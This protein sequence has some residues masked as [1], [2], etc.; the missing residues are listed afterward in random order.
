MRVVVERR[1]RCGRMSWAAPIVR[2]ADGLGLAA[3]DL[4]LAAGRLGAT[5][6]QEVRPLVQKQN[7]VRLRGYD[8]SDRTVPVLAISE[9]RPW[10][11]AHR[12]HRLSS[13]GLSPR[14]RR[15][16][17]SSP[18]ASSWRRP[19]EGSAGPAV[20]RS[21]PSSS[22]RSSP[23]TSSRPRGHSTSAT[24]SRRWRRGTVSARSGPAT[25][26]TTFCSPISGEVS[27]AA[28]MRPLRRPQL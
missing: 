4:G 17:R 2:R 9:D 27:P 26:G 16:P 24:V 11:R 15:L 5:A 19:A 6:D 12:R 8:P 7:A 10:T 14:T 21:S 1:L 3:A 13:R 22:W 28:D 20:G 23:Y 18:D 25:A